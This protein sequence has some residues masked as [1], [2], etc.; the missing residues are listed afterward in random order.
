[1]GIIGDVQGKTA[2]IVD[3]FTISGGTL[4][5]AA[6]QLVQHGASQVYAAVTHGAFSAGSME[7]IMDSPIQQL[8]ITDSIETQ[9]VPFCEKIEVISVARLLAEAIRRIHYHESISVLFE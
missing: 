1:M 4:V 6:K 3:D 2:V 7:R 9:T 8:L 5:E